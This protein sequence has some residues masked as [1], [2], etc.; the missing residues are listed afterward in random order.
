MIRVLSTIRFGGNHA[1]KAD[2][3]RGVTVSVEPISKSFEVNL[4]RLFHH[5]TSNGNG[6][7]DNLNRARLLRLGVVVHLPPAVNAVA[8][9]KEP[10]IAGRTAIWVLKQHM[11]KEP[12]FEAA[13][14]RTEELFAAAMGTT[15]H[16]NLRRDFAHRKHLCWGNLY[17]T[18]A[19]SLIGSAS[20]ASKEWGDGCQDCGGTT[21]D[22][23]S[24]F[25]QVRKNGVCEGVS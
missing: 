17:I 1:P 11:V 13:S 2:D 8:G 15:T 3:F 5:V 7:K 10:P 22:E 14:S 6:P 24:T 21:R 25:D 19:R 23:M 16:V 4:E 18:A 9:E 12:I 20:S